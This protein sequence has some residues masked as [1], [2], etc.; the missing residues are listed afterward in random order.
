MDERKIKATE[1]IFKQFKKIQNNINSRLETDKHKA[2]IERIEMIFK[3]V[4]AFIVE[5]SPSYVLFG[6]NVT[7]EG[8][9]IGIHKDDYSNGMIFI[10]MMYLKSPKL[11]VE[12]FVESVKSHFINTYKGAEVSEI[13]VNQHSKS[14]NIKITD[15]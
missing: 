11:N 5:D 12:R 14:M 9:D 7:Y 6:I 15:N 4:C 8:V 13:Y 10:S 3:G 2:I 1:A